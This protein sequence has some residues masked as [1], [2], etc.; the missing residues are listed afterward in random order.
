MC[1]TQDD[2]SAPWSMDTLDI[3][4]FSSWT[5]PL[6][7]RNTSTLKY[8]KRVENMTPKQILRAGVRADGKLCQAYLVA[9]LT[10]MSYK[11]ESSTG[12]AVWPKVVDGIPCFQRKRGLK[13]K[14][15]F[16]EK[17]GRIDIND[18]WELSKCL[19][20]QLLLTS[21]AIFVDGQD[22]LEAILRCIKEADHIVLELTDAHIDTIDPD[23]NSHRRRHG[24]TA[25]CHAFIVKHAVTDKIIIIY[26]CFQISSTIGGVSQY[27]LF[28]LFIL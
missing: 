14:D 23:F 7:R 10:L 27:D 8:M 4:V 20:T 6:N 28:C 19:I 25:V 17:L 13:P 9:G 16:D 24:A 1:T 21:K 5:R 11:V 2:I 22:M 18:C 15:D 26:S 12:I 3:S